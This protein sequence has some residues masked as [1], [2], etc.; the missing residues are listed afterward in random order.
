MVE[1][2]NPAFNN[3]SLSQLFHA[4]CDINLSLAN[5]FISVA[6]KRY[7]SL[8]KFAGTVIEQFFQKKNKFAGMILVSLFICYGEN[9]K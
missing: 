7:S 2:D 3:L 9:F 1:N 5:Q 6:E 8:Q 4:H